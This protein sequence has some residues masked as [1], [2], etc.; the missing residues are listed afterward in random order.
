MTDDE[1]RAAMEYA[2]FLSDLLLQ[3][4]AALLFSL[5]STLIFTQQIHPV[6][7][8]YRGEYGARVIATA[9]IILG[10]S[11]NTIEGHDRTEVLSCI[12]V[13]LGLLSPALEV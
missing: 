11:Q 7:S 1:D 8:M 13:M 2:A 12:E 4:G 6:E 3:E 5:P 9:A 10:Q